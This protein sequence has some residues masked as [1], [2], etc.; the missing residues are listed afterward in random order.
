MQI[1]VIKQLLFKD[2]LGQISSEDKIRLD[3]WLGESEE[4]RVL[5]DRLRSTPFLETAMTDDNR[6][7]RSRMWR[8]IVRQ[9]GAGRRYLLRRRAIRIAA[10]VAVPL[11]I[12]AVWL[13]ADLFRTETENRISMMDIRPGSPKVVVTLSNGEEMTFGE[14]ERIAVMREG[15]TTLVNEGN[16]VSLTT[17]N[18]EPDDDEYTVY[19][20][21]R[22]GEYAIKLADGTIVHMNS[23]SELRAPVKFGRGERVVY[24]RGEGYFEVTKD[25]HR[26]FIVKTARAGVE[27]LGTEFNVRAYDDEEGMFTTLVSGA[28]NIVDGLGSRVPMTPGTQATVGAHGEIV[29]RTVDTYP[30]I[31]WKSGRI[32]FDNARTEDIMKVLKRWYNCDVYYG[33]DAVKERRFTMDILK[34][35]DITEILDLMSMVNVSCTVRGNEVYLNSK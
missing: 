34:Y 21:P 5:Y 27:V 19:K 24:F 31:A 30:F 13:T 16:T 4:N 6:S 11:I 29:V 9:T 28:V 14:N 10:G 20:I 25:K 2:I 22:G 18:Y 35:D 15:T 8:E 12:G 1:R 26:P 23:E 3:E 17:Q 7:L 32:V 33:D